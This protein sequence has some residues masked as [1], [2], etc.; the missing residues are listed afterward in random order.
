[1]LN[2]IVNQPWYVQ[3]CSGKNGVFSPS[4][5][6]LS[7]PAKGLG[8]GKGKGGR[9][10]CMASSITADR[11]P[12]MNKRQLMNL[13]LLGA[14]SLPTAGMLVPYVAFI[15][16]PGFFFFYFILIS[17]QK[18]FFF[19]YRFPLHIYSVP[20]VPVVEVSPRMP[21]ETTYWRRRGWKLT[22]LAIKH[23]HRA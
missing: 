8:L 14:I 18:Q 15:V 6:L 7:K 12:D 13:L 21:S 16:P 1:M 22:A 23:L 3:L 20:V 19:P 10:T 11:V 2:F 17:F 9:V 4:K 5:A